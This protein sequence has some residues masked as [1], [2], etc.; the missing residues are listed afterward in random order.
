M[1]GINA[2]QFARFLLHQL[3]KY[4]HELNAHRAVVENFKVLLPGK[5]EEWLELYRNSP[6]IRSLTDKQFAGL[7]AIVEQLAEGQEMKALVELLQN[8]KPDGEPN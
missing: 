2:K 4:N 1:D 6:E 5:A 8:W 3:R 7:D